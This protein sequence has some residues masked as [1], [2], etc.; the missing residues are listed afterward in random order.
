MCWRAKRAGVR[1]TLHSAVPPMHLFALLPQPLRWML[2]AQAVQLNRALEGA[3]RGRQ[4]RG[5]H[6][7]PDLLSGQ[8]AAT[9]MAEDGYHPGPA[10][11]RRW[12]D[13]LAERLAAEW[14]RSH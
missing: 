1:Y 5:L 12:A 14:L 9:L 3:L 2:G 6:A 13:T 10:G 4:D 11:Y 8:E 7:M